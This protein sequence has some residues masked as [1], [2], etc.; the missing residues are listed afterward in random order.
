MVVSLLLLLVLTACSSIRGR[1]PASSS[2][3]AVTGSGGFRAG[4]SRVEFTPPP[5]YPMG[6]HSKAGRVARGFWTRLHA[7]AIFVEDATGHQV[8]LVSCD[9]W[10]LPAGLGDRVAEL[11]PGEPFRVALTRDQLVLAATHTHQSPG[12]YSSCPLYNEFASPQA[13]FDAD[14]FEF[15][16]RR[17]AEAVAQ[18][19]HA[20][21]PARLF[22]AERPLGLV[23]RNR[24][25]PAFVRDPEAEHILQE[26]AALPCGRRLDEYPAIEAYRAVDPVLKVLRLESSTGSA[27][28]I[29]VAGFYGVH[30]TAMSHTTEFYTSD[31]FGVAS[32]LV[33]HRLISAS[34]PGGRAPV[35]A[36]FNGAEG[37]ISPAWERQD[38]SNTLQI[39]RR[40]A[41]GLSSLLSGG[42]PLTG[43]LNHRYTSAP[44]ANV[45]FTNWD[46]TGLRTADLPLAGA[47]MLGGAEDGRTS[48]HAEGY[49][50]GITGPPTRDH[51][52]KLGALDFQHVIL[53][54]LGLGPLRL[55]CLAMPKSSLPR[56][57]PLGLYQFGGVSGVTLATLPG[58][59]TLV[60]GRR[61]A[62]TVRTNLAAG[63]SR[64]LLA[65]L[66]NEYVSYFTTP[67]EY[68]A[69]HYEGASMLYGPH[70]GTLVGW[71][72]GSLA[73][74]LDPTTPSF[75]ARAFDYQSGGRES[76]GV[77]RL[78]HQRAEEV[79]A[80][81][82]EV[83]GEAPKVEF[84]WR[85]STPRRGP[86]SAFDVPVN[87][88][89]GVEVNRGGGWEPLLVDGVEETN[90]GLDF[91][92]VLA[93]VDRHGT[94]WRAIWMPPAD[95]ARGIDCR[96][97]VEKLD[98]IVT[99]SEPFPW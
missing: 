82:R 76:F 84:C 85:D 40:L 10:S 78:R 9:L 62:E 57:V 4:S 47:P 88:R 48:Y 59:F 63:T 23:A 91:L 80:A 29:A 75:E 13:G 7:R 83:V 81:V 79:D 11:L 69:Q 51:G 12:N 17:I 58:E 41:E 55:T 72:L 95:L 37:D 14:L 46:G 20:A 21:G 89:V 6:G 92:T 50:E 61:I 74:S 90:E 86:A 45:G 33:E 94:S 27:R 19:V 52:V 64:V 68:A 98:G 5:G 56:T 18:A 73:R 28:L 70:A 24:S 34:A 32:T 44:L 65:G 38:R 71:H 3:A 16:A 1:L 97:R 49:V 42:T 8:A 66:A 31:L 22:Y 67:E 96:I 35:V 30:P 60:M 77:V 39:G 36:L 26:N 99:W 43:A 54:F 93:A 15:L 25:Y 2:S 53:Q 87:P